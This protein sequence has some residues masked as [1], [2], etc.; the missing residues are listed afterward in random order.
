MLG[1]IGGVGPRATSKFYLDLVRKHSALEAGKLPEFILAN[2]GLEKSIEDALVGEGKG[3]DHAA[4]KMLEIL[5]EKSAQLKSCGCTKV[6]VICNTLQCAARQV[7][8]DVGLRLVEFGDSV[9]EKVGASGWD[10]VCVVS[11]SRSQTDMAYESRLRE[12]GVTVRGWT[13]A[14]RSLIARDV[15][16]FVQHERPNFSPPTISVLRRAA[17]AGQGILLAC[18]DIFATDLPDDLRVKAVASVDFATDAALNAIR[19]HGF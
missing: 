11:G 5:R 13:D 2:A 1:V 19:G 6:I 3:A 18:T 8:A 9:I 4:A 7:C 16:G 14:E 17:E 12:L 15:L 10:T